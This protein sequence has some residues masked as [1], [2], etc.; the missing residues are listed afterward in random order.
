MIK[1]KS[2]EEIALMQESALI[3]SKTL[4]MLAKEIKPGISTLKLDKLADEFIRDHNATPGFLGLYDFPNTLCMSPNEQVVHGIPNNKPL[5]DGDIISIDC[6]AKKN[7]FYGDHA[8]T[9]EVGEV[10][11]EIKNLLKVTKE[12]L[13]KGIAEFRYGK[14]IGD[15]GYAIQKHAEDHGY[16]VVRELVGHGLGKKMHEDP[17]MPNYG[18]RGRGKKFKNGMTVAIEP[19]INLGYRRVIQ[20][21]DGWT[22]ITADGLPSAHFEH[23]VA[24]IDGKP[25][26][27]ST[28][29][30]VYEALGISSD[31]EKPFKFE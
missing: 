31:E 22:I 27:L 3:V 13:Y 9:F 10:K 26:L 14:R 4:G 15:V 16:G 1:L 18:K 12:S 2:T 5:N 19:M 29:D 21:K 25:K 11:P 7:G 20:L 23:D 8:Y 28:F 24:L 6:G 17:E 30:F